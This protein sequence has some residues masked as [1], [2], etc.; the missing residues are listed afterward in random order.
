MGTVATVFPWRVAHKRSMPLWNSVWFICLY[1]GRL[2]ASAALDRL[3]STMSTRGP[4]TIFRR[5]NGGY[6]ALRDVH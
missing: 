1:R 6:P 3:A 5:L 2:L 4:D